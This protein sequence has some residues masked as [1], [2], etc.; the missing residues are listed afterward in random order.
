M[1]DINDKTDD[2]VKIGKELKKK[3]SEI[4][5]NF[6]IKNFTAIVD[7]IPLTVHLF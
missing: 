7:S 3:A 1:K 6:R 2:L 4:N 5:P